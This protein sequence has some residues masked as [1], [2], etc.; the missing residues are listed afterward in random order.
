MNGSKSPPS[1][2]RSPSDFV[3]RHVRD[4]PRSGIRDFFEIVE[5]RQDV[6]SL[7]IGE[8]DFVTPWRIREAAIY[9]LDRGATSYT[10]NL[11]TLRLRKAIARYVQAQTGVAYDPAAEILVTV[12]VSEA[13]DLA[14]RAIVNPGDAVLYH[15]PSYVSYAPV[16]S[17]AHARPLAVRTAPG[18][19]FRLTGPMLEP[20]AAQ[21]PRALLLSFPTNP[22][23][24]VLQREDLE[25][26]AAFAAEQDMLVLADDI[27]AGLT[28]DAEPRSIVSLPGMRERTIYLNG[29]SKSWAMTGFRIGYACAPAPLIEAMMKIHQYTMLCAPILSQEAA[30]EAL[31]HSEKE[32]A[33]MREEYR[34]RRNVIHRGLEEMGLP[35]HRPGGAFYAFPSIAHLGLSS[36]DFAVRL[37]ES[38]NVACVPGTAFGPSGEG[39]LRCCFATSMD[40]LQE[41]LN[42]MARF[43][44]TLKP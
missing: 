39:H 19:G 21:A 33:A 32:T 26:V 24:G 25:A 28:F 15:E 14:V 10:A 7:S 38:E 40:N 41:A 18:N 13:L 29:L 37:L 35:C 44:G 36:L 17:L 5:T 6:I 23:G 11:G 2:R 12:G 4:I 1:P 16:I 34:R 8:P 22:T 43:V 42:R 30:I 20:F 31:L 3:A 27:Y 9:A